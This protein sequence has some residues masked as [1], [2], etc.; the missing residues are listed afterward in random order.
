MKKRKHRA[1]KLH[2]TNRGNLSL[3]FL[4]T[5]S[6]FT[7]VLNQNNL[8]IIKGRDH[9]LIDCGTKCSQ[10]LH[11]L[12]IAVADIKNYLITHSHAD[13]VGGLEE[14]MLFGR[15]VARKKPNMVVTTE[16]EKILWEQSLMG[17]A[18]H[19]ETGAQLKFKDFWHAIRPS[20]KRNY[21]RETLEVNIGS[22]NLKLPRTMH[23]PDRA[24]SWEDSFWSCGVIVDDRVLYTSDTRFD[25]DLILDFDERLNFE[26][27][28]HDCQFFNGGVHA[29]L[30]ELSRLPEAIKKKI[31]LMHYGDNWQQ[32]RQQIKE[33]GFHSFAEQGASYNFSLV[34]NPVISKIGL[35]AH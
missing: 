22:I 11:E 17:G 16:Y 30:E 5:G 13:H 19:S 31:I 3:F 25:P 18:A 7:K 15:Y 8:L 32:F 1:K 24:K 9:I 2:L 4:G 27:I 28:F 29:S 26:Y 23:I 14:A 35:A 33:A 21:P 34:C 10:A 6:A 20:K 12:G